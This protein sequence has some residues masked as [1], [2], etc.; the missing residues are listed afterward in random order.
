M[1]KI[2]LMFFIFNSTLG[3]SEGYTATIE[4]IKYNTFLSADPADNLSLGLFS[5]KSNA[6]FKYFNFY[7]FQ[8]EGEIGINYIHI[9]KNN[10]CLGVSSSPT[11]PLLMSCTPDTSKIR[12]DELP[13]TSGAVILSNIESKNCLVSDNNTFSLIACPG[14]DVNLV[15]SKFLW[16]IGP[17]LTPMQAIDLRSKELLFLESVFALDPD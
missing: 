15:D 13:T 8:D 4:N 11:R 16:N 9:K 7:V 5:N 14:S 10:K 2:L 6:E 12:W 17:R 1:K 3:F